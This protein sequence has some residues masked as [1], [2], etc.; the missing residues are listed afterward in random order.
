MAD[1]TQIKT[2]LVDRAE[3]VVERLL[4]AGKLTSGEWCVGSIHGEAGQSL[5][6]CIKGAKRGI[7]SDFASGE[8][9]D[10]IDLWC[11]V[12]NQAVAEALPEIK[13]FLG[14]TEPKL[15]KELERNYRMPK[16]PAS[17]KPANKV[18]HHLCEECCLPVT[19]LE[20][21][22]VGEDGDYAF[23]P[24]LK[25]GTLHLVKR[26]DIKLNDKGKHENKP[27]EAGCRPILFGW[28]IIPDDARTVVITEGEKD[29]M[30]LYA[31]GY[32]A[33]SVPFGGGG[34]N[35]QKQWI[36]NDYPDL[37]RFEV[38][39]LAL[40]ND[41]EGEIAAKQIAQQL[42]RHRCK[43]VVLPHKDANDCLKEGVAPETIQLAFDNATMYEP[44]GLGLASDFINDVIALH[45]AKQ[46]NTGCRL[47]FPD[48]GKKMRFQPGD[49]TIW[50]GITGHG[51]TQ[52]TSFCSIDW[53]LSQGHPTCIASLEM[54]A[55]QTLLRMARQVAN[56]GALDAQTISAAIT[57]L[58][59]GRMTL[60][61]HVG[62]T[63]IDGLL[64]IFDYA[65]ARYGC[66]QFIIDSLMR[67]GVAGDDYT[68]QEAVM[69]KIVE[70]A[71][72][73]ETHVHLVAHVKKGSDDLRRGP[74]TSDDLKGA[75]EVAA[76]AANIIMVWRNKRKEDKALNGTI[77]EQ[78]EAAREPAVIISVEKQRNGDF[79]G[80]IPLDFVTSSYQYREKSEG[81]HG[82]NYLQL[83]ENL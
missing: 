46:S 74:G 61:D 16:R 64:E 59:Q 45:H 25:G 37:E 50:G 69:F 19:A 67:L 20:A 21:Y 38:I 56:T 60:F 39:Y 52:L 30:S 43:R 17:K 4:P 49:V 7:W 47:P 62:K 51:K 23:F 3:S 22:K 41:E 12:T 31:Y 70:W 32:P 24:F 11:A 40:D 1:I 57:A 55:S 83:G 10:L 54:S 72:T 77:D 6:V 35:K 15:R 2:M 26:Y 53:V 18:F 34:G 79:E 42:G 28:H 76:Q 78:A 9:G 29:A 63:D 13:A 66:E 27:T 65:R 33:L 75:M 36:E 5:K 48:A 81:Y 58:G 73:N 14:V 68:G 80:K 71:R 8:G 82:R 44:A